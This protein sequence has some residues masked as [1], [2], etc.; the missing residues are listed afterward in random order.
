MKKI[1]F[2]VGTRP[3]FIKIYPVISLMR[4]MKSGSLG[5]ASQYEDLEAVLVETNQHKDLLLDMHNFFGLKPDYIF[6]MQDSSISLNYSSVRAGGGQNAESA[7]ATDSLHL[8]KLASSILSSAIDFLVEHKPDMV[9]VQGDTISACQVAL[10]AWYLKIPVAHIEAGLRTYDV[11]QPYPEELSRRIIDHLATLNFAATPSAMD[12]LC[13]EKI[14][15][16][17]FLTGNTVVD[18]LAQVRNSN[19]FISSQLKISANT[20][21]YVLITAHR[22]ENQK[23]VIGELAKA[24]EKLAEDNSHYNFI[25]IKHANPLANAAFLP[26]SA[27]ENVVLREA[28][29][30]PE[31]LALISRAQLI[32]SDSGGIQEEAPYFGVPVLVL[33]ELTERN[34]SLERG[35]SALAGTDASTIYDRVHRLINPD[36]ISNSPFASKQKREEF[37]TLA[38]MREAIRLNQNLYGD[39]NA[40]ARIIRHLLASLGAFQ[41]DSNKQTA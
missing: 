12:N 34:E 35:L 40:S 26:L 25:I 39:G 14:K 32:I 6:A 33:R 21:P 27:I 41:L 37:A 4:Q 8:A 38:D 23:L 13:Y 2:I 11:E 22:R 5:D 17:N 3:E 30:Y 18:A 24:I 16:R 20:K 15:A 28:V 1:Y 29:P 36:L 10:A 9:V 31:F 19:E 7:L